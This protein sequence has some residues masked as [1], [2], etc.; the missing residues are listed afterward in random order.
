[1]TLAW[2]EGVGRHVL[3][4]TDSTMAEAARRA[5]SALGPEW[6]L[7]F[8]Q[9]AGRGRRGRA[10]SMPAGNFAASLILHPKEP[11]Q[12]VA[13]RSFVAA[14]AL[15]DALVALG[16]PATDLA[17]KWPN[18]VLLKG[19]KLAGILLE[20]LG[21][22]RGGLAHL[23]IGIGVNLA[24]AP[25]PSALEATAVAPVS[26]AADAGVQVGPEDVLNALAPAYADLEAQFTTYGFAP[27][28]NA[29]LSKAARLGEVITARLP[30]DEITGTF[31][32]VDMDG[33]LVLETL[34]GR[35]TIAAADIFF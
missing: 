29:W 2:P 3:P 4:S 1:M 30:T 22:G 17:L 21:D 9:T 25:E 26:L 13:L 35:R 16:V 7:A 24:A 27:I 15:H 31:T 12:Q 14:L 11:P 34:K 5:P 32:D 23:V 20:S 10:W 19:G 28:R 18:D 33:N 6:V 8:E